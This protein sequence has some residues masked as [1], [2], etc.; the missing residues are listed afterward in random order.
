MIIVCIEPFFWMDFTFVII[1]SSFPC[2][3]NK[4]KLLE[5]NFQ[6]LHNEYQQTLVKIK[7]A[8][9]LSAIKHPKFVS[10]MLKKNCFAIS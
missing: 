8:I 6:H 9:I 4:L 7:Q 5:I 3:R 2:V 10:I 1:V